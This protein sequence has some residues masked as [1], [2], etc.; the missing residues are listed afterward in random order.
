MFTNHYYNSTTRKI[1]SIFGTVFNDFS[2]IRKDSNGKVLSTSKVPIA[3]GPKDKFL[4]RTDGQKDVSVSNIAIK[5]PRLSFEITGI[6]YNDNLKLNRFGKIKR[7]ENFVYTFAPYTIDFQLNL[8]AKQKDDALQVMEQ[9]LPLFQPE[10]TVSYFPLEDLP[11]IQEDLPI[12]LKNVTLNDNYEGSFVER[13]VINYTF[14]FSVDARFYGP[15]RES[16]VINNVDIDYSSS[17]DFDNTIQSSS[18]SGSIDTS[19]EII[20]EETHE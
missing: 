14:D 13:R 15:V 10:F 3:Y 2:I 16:K 6:T 5:L 20:V 11:D 18:Y 7:D 1:V 17:A 9:I 4:A 8:L 12:V 19:G